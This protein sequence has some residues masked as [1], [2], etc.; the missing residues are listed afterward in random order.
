MKAIQF[1]KIVPFLFIS[2]FIFV[3]CEKEAEIGPNDVNNVVLEFDNYVADKKLVL[4]N[5]TYTNA[6][7]EPF[8]VSTFNY[9]V[10]NIELVKEDGSVFTYPKNDSYFLIKETE[11]ASKL[12]TL[13]NIPAANY[14]SVRFTIGIDSL[15]NVSPVEER[16]GVLDLANNMYWSWNSGYIFVK[17]EGTSTASPADPTGQQKFRFHIGGFGGKD[18]KTINNIKTVTLPLNMAAQVRKDKVPTV[19]IITDA[20]KLFT[21]LTNVRLSENSTTMFNPYSVNIA[22]N[23]KTMFTIDHVHND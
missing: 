9:Y 2:L 5:A 19:H 3:S 20:S 23:Y 12:V 8:T 6:V 13:K 15:K 22:N 18:S 14:T 1:L 10:S 7:G 4:D 16:T 11:A 17:L 21:G